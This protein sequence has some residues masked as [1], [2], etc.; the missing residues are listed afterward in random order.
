[1]RGHRPVAW[2]CIVSL[3]SGCTSLAVHRF[4]PAVDNQEG[5][6]HVLPYT[7]YAV[8]LTWRVVD[9]HVRTEGRTDSAQ[10]AVKAEATIGED[11]DARHAY[12]V[13]PSSVQGLLTQSEFKATY[14][15]DSSL[16]RSV[17]LSIEDRT[18]PFIGNIVRTAV[19]LAPVLA[20]ASPNPGLLPAPGGLPAPGAAPSTPC[21]E[22]T[23]A[24][25][26]LVASLKGELDTV[27]R[28]TAAANEAVTVIAASVAQLGESVDDA[29]A[30]RYGTAV[31]TLSDLRARQARL[32][33]QLADALKAVT[34]QRVIRWPTDSACFA[35]A[36]PY[37]V[38]PAA[39]ARWFRADVERPAVP[40]VH[41]AIERAGS[42][43]RDPS[44]CPA[45]DAAP[46]A[47]ANSP[48]RGTLTRGLPFRIPARGRLVACTVSPC[49]SEDVPNVLLA[50][51]GQVAQLGAVN[52]LRVRNR[53]FGTTT[54]AADFRPNGSLA[55]AGYTQTAPLEGASDT[56][57]SAVTSLA[58][59]F[60]PTQQLTRDTAH[61]NALKAQ[62]DAL[63]AVTPAAE[64]PSAAAQA[65][66]TAETSLLN[67]RIAQLQAQITLETLQ[68]S[69]RPQ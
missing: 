3:L 51:E 18:G 33:A 14:Q 56:G 23:E 62:R 8:T 24:A 54:F 61:L 38:H 64:D 42:F 9:C 69:R 32:A 59:L 58:P 65:A 46:Q 10:I 35:T 67:A 13:D 29:T 68:A 55:S 27:N 6:P 15:D 34:F 4:N 7:Q 66:I 48:G 63:A 19:A 45:A 49:R 11:D 20:G 30:A 21:T 50:V 57:A 26:A 53:P 12:R 41:L 2:A 37:A 43:G 17:N 44:G 52:V 28:E 47:Q 16:L 22:R 31:Q 40:A 1:M 39:L 5:L 36:T 60:D 25:V